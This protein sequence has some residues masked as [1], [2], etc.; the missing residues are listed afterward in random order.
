MVR[1]A[2]VTSVACTLPRVRFQISQLSMVPNSDVAGRLQ[3][4]SHSS[5]AIPA[6]WPR[7]KDRAAARSCARSSAPSPSPSARRSGRRRAGPARRWR[8]AAAR[9][10]FLSQISEVSRWL[11]MPMAATSAACRALQ[12]RAAAGQRRLPDFRR[13]HAPPSH[14]RDRSGAS[15]TAWLATGRASPSNRMARVEVVPWSMAR[16]KDLLLSCVN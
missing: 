14:W 12:H 10:L 2:L 11:V 4:P 9:P 13:R 3:R 1:E 8:C 7:N 5:A 16:R 15:G 6:W